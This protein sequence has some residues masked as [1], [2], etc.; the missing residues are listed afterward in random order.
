[1]CLRGRSKCPLLAHSRH[2]LLHYKCP[3]LA[4]ERTSITSD[5]HLPEPMSAFGGKA[6]IPFC[7][8][9]ICYF[10]I[11]PIRS[12]ASSSSSSASVSPSIGSHHT[13]SAQASAVLV[14]ISPSSNK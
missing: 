7:T 12:S 1:M 11:P 2:G 13:S 6:D 4:V 10:L 8:A 14:S 5:N 3:L 9:N